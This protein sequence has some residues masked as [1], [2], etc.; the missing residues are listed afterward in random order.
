MTFKII[1]AALA[2]AGIVSPAYAQGAPVASEGPRA[3]VRVGFDRIKIKAHYDD[4]VDEFS[5]SD[6]EDGVVYGAEFGYDKL[7]ATNFTLGAYA[8]V[9]FSSTDICSEVYGNDEACLDAGR[10]ITLGVRA[11]TALSPSIFVY[12]KGGFSNG[13]VT[14]SYED[15]DNI[16]DDFKVVENRD[17]YHLGAGAEFRFSGRAYGK[18]EYVYTDYDDFSESSSGLSYGLEPSRHQVLTGVGIRF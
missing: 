2:T 8:G 10:N 1:A 15:F 5:G 16:I 12:A 13:R 11:G 14:A 17:G 3:E 18:V 9:D 7:V 6:H 4:G